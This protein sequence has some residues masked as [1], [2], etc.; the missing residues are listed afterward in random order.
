MIRAVCA[1]TRV[2]L[3]CLPPHSSHLLQPLD[4]L[5]FSR[6]KQFHAQLSVAPDLS[7]ISR[8]LLTIIIA[9]EQSQSRYIIRQSWAINDRHVDSLECRKVM[10]ESNFIDDMNKLHGPR[11]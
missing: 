8:A 6:L 3:I 10:Q 2:D 1:A 9:F 4:R 5:Y 11:G 7:G